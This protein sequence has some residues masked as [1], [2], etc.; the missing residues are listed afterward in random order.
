[1][2]HQILYLY[3]LRLILNHHDDVA[4]LEVINNPRRGIGNYTLDRIKEYAQNESLSY[5]E[6]ICSKE[7]LYKIE[8][9][10]N[11]IKMINKFTTIIDGCDLLVYIKELIKDLDYYKVLRSEKNPKDKIANVDTFLEMIDEIE[12]KGS[13]IDTLNSLLSDIYLD[14]T[15][16]PQDKNYVKLMTIHQAKGLEY[17]I[18]ILSGCNDGI[19]PTSHDKKTIQEERRLFYVALTRAKERLYLLSSNKRLVNGQYKTYPIS[20]FVLEINKTTV[21]FN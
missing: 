17:K 5:Y 2:W 13:P 6:T 11:F 12:I 9:I 18:V 19:I 21:N 10:A 14:A 3:Y 7:D 4:F 16:P 15:K 20:P 1:M 8:S